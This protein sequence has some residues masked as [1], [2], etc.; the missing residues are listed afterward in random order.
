MS[1]EQKPMPEIAFVVGRYASGSGGGGGSVASS[2]G[3]EAV[4]AASER[5][6][7]EAKRRR[8][9]YEE[10][11]RQRKRRKLRDKFAAAALTGLLAYEGGPEGDP[12]T[13][14]PK[15]AYQYADAMLAERDKDGG[16]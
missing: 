6:R 11:K 3:N 1:E 9:E 5:E 10:K 13:Y 8:A 7:A 2:G 15:R 12:M 16:E 14:Y 4:W